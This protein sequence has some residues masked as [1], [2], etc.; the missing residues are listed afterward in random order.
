M[1]STNKQHNKKITKN[2]IMFQ[3]MVGPLEALKHNTVVQLLKKRQLHLN[4]VCS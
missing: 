2:K 4:L 3:A 1:E